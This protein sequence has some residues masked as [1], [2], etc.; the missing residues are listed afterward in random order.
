M[1]T[2][3]I[4]APLVVA[5]EAVALVAAS[6]PA[7]A[8]V[9]RVATVGATFAGQSIRGAG[10]P[11]S[12][13]TLKVKEKPVPHGIGDCSMLRYLKLIASAM[14]I[15]CGPTGPAARIRTFATPRVQLAM[16]AP[17]YLLSYRSEAPPS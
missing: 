7:V 8:S 3:D 1:P 4:T 10:R 16:T 5:S 12:F 6:S 14:S 11:L 2:F 13:V 9:V 17:T 15:V